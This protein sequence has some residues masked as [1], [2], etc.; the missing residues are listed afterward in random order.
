MD[1]M[2]NSNERLCGIRQKEEL[3]EVLARAVIDIGL[4]TVCVGAP[5]RTLVLTRISIGTQLIQNTGD[6]NGTKMGTTQY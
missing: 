5:T 2:N 6:E 3:A 1:L 4:K